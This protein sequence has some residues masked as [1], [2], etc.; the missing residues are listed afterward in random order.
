MQQ[1]LEALQAVLHSTILLRPS[2]ESHIQ[3][4]HSLSGSKHKGHE[5]K[6]Q[7]EPHPVHLIEGILLGSGLSQSL[8]L[9]RDCLPI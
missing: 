1:P 8:G 9:Q 7:Q 3:E 2:Q 6:Y 5:A 4:Q